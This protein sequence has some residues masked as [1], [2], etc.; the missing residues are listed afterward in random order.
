MALGVL[1]FFIY[2]VSCDSGGSGGGDNTDNTPDNS[3]DSDDVEITPPSQNPG[4][5]DIDPELQVQVD[6]FVREA[7]ARGIDVSL[8]GL[9]VQFANFSG[10]ASGQCSTNGISREVLV[11]DVFRGRPNLAFYIV[12]HE[13]GHCILRREH[14][15]D[16]ISIMNTT[17]NLS[18]LNTLDQT[19][20]IDELFDENFFNQF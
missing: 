7:N 3:V 2:L 12:F 16:I 4:N 5:S 20:L 1:S 11:S 15:D 9:S 18:E 8:S 17:I 10:G 13:L 14:R 19:A 6:A